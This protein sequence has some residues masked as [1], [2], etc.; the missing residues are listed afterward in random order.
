MLVHGRV[1]IKSLLLSLASLALLQPG[2][3]SHQVNTSPSFPALSFNRIAYVEGTSQKT[4]LKV[5]PLGDSIT[6][7]TRD[8]RY[9]GYRNQLGTLLTTDGYSID[10]VGS[11]QSGNGVIPDPDNEGHPGWTIPQIKNGIDSNRWL[12]TYRPDIILLHIGTNDLREG[13]AASAPGN[14][15]TLLD[16]I[17]MRLPQTHVIVAQIIPFRRGPDRVHESYNSA[18]AGIVESKGPRVSMVDMQNILSPSDYAD[19]L[20]LMLVATTSWHVLGNLQ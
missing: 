18:I 9:G 14:L 17:L 6:F 4:R 11:R 12:E 19:G 16:D 15:S 7:G 10:F 8:P 13:D 3:A 1:P 2:F 5:T 20:I